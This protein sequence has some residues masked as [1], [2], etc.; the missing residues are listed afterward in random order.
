MAVSFMPGPKHMVLFGLTSN[1][2]TGFRF[3]CP[4][5]QDRSVQAVNK[6]MT[7]EMKTMHDIIPLLILLLLAGLLL[8]SVAL[9]GGPDCWPRCFR[10]R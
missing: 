8:A 6:S 7:T 4:D 5:I 2:Q 9:V 3:A 10:V 1:R